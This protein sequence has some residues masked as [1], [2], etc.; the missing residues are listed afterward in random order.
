PREDFWDTS[1]PGF[2]FRVTRLGAKSFCLV[3]RLGGRDSDKVRLT[4]GSYPQLSLADARSLARVAQG[5]IERGIDPRGEAA[6]KAVRPQ[7]LTF[8]GLA[9]HYLDHHPKR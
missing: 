1:L 5:Q 3:F 2:G 9:T 8:E 6:P 4:L 7:E